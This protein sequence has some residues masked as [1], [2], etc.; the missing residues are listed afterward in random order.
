P[1][2]DEEVTS[3]A[4]YVGSTSGIMDFAKKSSCK[5]FIIGTENS[6]VEHLE[7]ECPDK[8][9][10]PLS[11]GLVCLNMRLTT[12]KSVYD[13]LLGGGEEI[14]LDEP[15]RVAAKKCIDKMIALGG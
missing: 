10:Y 3:K 9:F 1:E 5:E 13:C 8:K 2:C 14:T 15:L 12:L 11:K 7:Y 6:I 4:D